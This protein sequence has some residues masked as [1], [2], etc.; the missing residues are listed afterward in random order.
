MVWDLDGWLEVVVYDV[1]VGLGEFWEMKGEKVVGWGRWG[2]VGIEDMG[3]EGRN[4]GDE[5][6]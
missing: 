4:R 6:G 2:E 5:F 3:I 1:L